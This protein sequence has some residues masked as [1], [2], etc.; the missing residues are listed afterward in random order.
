MSTAHKTDCA[1]VFKRYDM[2]CPRCQELAGGAP[3]RAGWNDLKKRNE[4]MRVEA[5]RQHDFT[6]CA[7]Q[8]H[9]VCTCFEW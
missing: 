4:L 5:I 7:K 9:G 1:R 6:A 2:S 3:A 8:H